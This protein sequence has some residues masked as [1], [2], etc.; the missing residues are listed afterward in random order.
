MKPDLKNLKLI[1]Y[2]ED[3]MD[4]KEKFNEVKEKFDALDDGVK[5][6]IAVVTGLLLLTGMVY[7]GVTPEDDYAGLN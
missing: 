6:A 5:I 3:D 7:I 2:G 1:T 4:I